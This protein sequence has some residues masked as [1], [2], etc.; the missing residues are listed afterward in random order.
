MV[1]YPLSSLNNLFGSQRFGVICDFSS[2]E[3]VFLQAYNSKNGTYFD[4]AGIFCVFE[5]I[6]SAFLMF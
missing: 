3:L 5:L 4:R 1:H 2:H 6:F